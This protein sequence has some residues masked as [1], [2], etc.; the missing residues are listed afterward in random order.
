MSKNYHKTVERTV[1]VTHCHGQYLV[2]GEFWDFAAYLD[3]DYTLARAQAR[4]RRDLKDQT[5][6]INKIEKETARY[7]M[8]LAQFISQSEKIQL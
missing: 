7:R 2:N 4:L 1:T 8:P 5:I 6:T 3:G